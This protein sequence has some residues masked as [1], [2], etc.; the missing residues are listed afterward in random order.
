MTVTRFE[1]ASPVARYWLANCEG[2]AV[3]GDAR[4]VVEALIRD[5]D[6]HVTTRLVIRTPTRRRK[7]VPTGRVAAVVPAERVLVVGRAHRRRGRRPRPPIGLATA[8]VRTRARS[9]A[10]ALAAA[11]PPARSAVRAARGALSA[12]GPPA[13]SGA[14]VA[15]GALATAAC[16]ALRLGGP[17]AATLARSLRLLVLEARATARSLA[18]AAGQASAALRLRWPSSRQR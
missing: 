13:R 4:G 14:L 8:E 16:D 7:I 5:S 11:G 10:A 15:R 12:A 17:A 18:A 9:V 2:F 6:P 3:K 1:G